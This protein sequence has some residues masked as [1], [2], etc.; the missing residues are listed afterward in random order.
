MGKYTLIVAEKPDSANRIAT[1]LDEDGKPKKGLI[2][3]VPYYQAYRDG[4]IV[5]VPALGHLYT[6]TSKKKGHTYPVFEYQW[7][8]RYQ[9][10]RG[11]SRIRTWLKVISQL[12]M[13][14]EGFVDACDFDIEGSIIGY[15]IL[16]YACGGK[17]KEAKK[18]EI[19][20]SHQGR[21]PRI[22]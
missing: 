6:I 13:D 15:S 21:T 19:L 2:S 7:V 20:H 10:E 5:V 4:N 3:G 16:K 14:A 1:A 8:P 22:L 12:A 9:A 17:E 18:N 11:A